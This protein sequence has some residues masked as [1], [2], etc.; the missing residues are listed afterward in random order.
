MSSEREARC[1]TE[2]LEA[3]A[4]ALGERMRRG[5][6]PASKVLAAARCGDPRARRLYPDPATHPIDSHPGL[7]FLSDSERL[8]F[9]CDCA[10]R[11]LPVFER[12]LPENDKLRSALT[13]I[14][15]VARGQAP[16]AELAEARDLAAQASDDAEAT[17]E[18]PLR[19][20]LPLP[21]QYF[22]GDIQGLAAR[23]SPSEHDI[24]RLVNSV[25]RSAGPAGREAERR[26]QLLRLA[27]YLLGEAG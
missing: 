22:A 26:W 20:N 4:A 12:A 24:L 18:V 9:G 5:E 7:V 27:Q 13:I 19:I 10:E 1:D 11:L 15:R 3:G 6:L 8:L 21:I 25:G 14:R 2:D 17:R 16:A 23:A